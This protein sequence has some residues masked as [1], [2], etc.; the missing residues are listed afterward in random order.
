M[1]V[2]VHVPC[3]LRM[4]A[5]PA[6]GAVDAVVAGFAAAVGRA[7]ATADREVLAPRSATAV[8]APGEPTF[9][10]HGAMASRVPVDARVQLEGRLRAAVHE[11]LAVPLPRTESVAAR[12]L[13]EPAAE[14]FDRMRAR[15]VLRTYRVP[16]YN[17]GGADADIEF[18]EA[19]V[20]TPVTH[21]WRLLQATGT[22]TGR[23]LVAEAVRQFGE[24]PGGVT[25][26]LLA[27]EQLATGPH[28]VVTL[29]TTPAT[30]FSFESFG[31]DNYNPATGRFDVTL[32]DPPVA[33]GSVEKRSVTDR[34]QLVAVIDELMGPGIEAQIQQAAPKLET[35][36]AAE[37]GEQVRTAVA[38]EVDRRA[39]EQLKLL[40][41]KAPACVVIVRVGT[42]FVVLIGDDAIA[43][44]LHWTGS[45]NVWPV[46]TEHAVART[47]TG[48]EPADG[49]GGEA[50]GGAGGTGKGGTDKGGGGPGGTGDG[51]P[52][53]GGGTGGGTGTGTGGP[54]GFVVDPTLPATPGDEEVTNRFPLVAGGGETPVCASFNGEPNLTELGP[55]GDELRRLID[56]IAFRLQI[57]PCYFAAN[58]CL[59]AAGA[60]RARAAAIST[61]I[62]TSERE[63]FTQPVPER[64][65]DLGPIRFRPVASPATQFLRHL[66][67]VVP[68]LHGLALFALATYRDPEH[69]PKVKGGW[70]N[71]PASWALHFLTE[72]TPGLKAAV[73]EIFVSGSQALLLQ[74]LLS[75]RTGI[76]TR[77][78][79]FEQYAPIFERLMVTQLTDYA[80][81]TEL[82]SA[83][84][85]H[86]A[87]AFVHT[88]TGSDLAAVVSVTNPATAWFGAA[89]ALSGAFLASEQA[90]SAGAKGEIVT[91]DGVT[92]IR[93]SHGVLWTQHEL[94]SAMV[95]RRGEA[96]GIDPL[97]KQIADVPEV[98]ERFQQN[99]DAIRTELRAV[100]TEMSANNTEMLAKTRADAWFAFRAS[101]ISEHIPSATVS[102]S[103][104]A[105]QGIHL[106]VHEELG[107][108]F[109]GDAFYALGID[110][111][112]NGELGR[113]ELT[114]FGIT[115][116]I[117][118]LSVLCPPLGIA[119]GVAY[120]GV[121]VVRAHE[122]A[123]IHGA[124]VD[125]ELVIDRATVELELFA[126][127]LG[128]ALSLVP[129][130]GAL[131]KS[132]GRGGL[133]ALRTGLRSG[134]RT[135]L[136]MGTAAARRDLVRRWNRMLIE[137]AKQD[138][139]TAFVTELVSDAVL[140]RVVSE[141]MGPLLS[142]VERE[143]RITG[144]VGGREGARFVIAVLDS[145]STTRTRSLP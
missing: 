104:Y 48:A 136:R 44:T 138:L 52:G 10:W 108:F 18:L 22:V 61:Y 102:G 131:A 125:P 139:L 68:R 91:T 66:A 96:E 122:R 37:Y 127:Y 98:L 60:L 83:L 75:S 40:A 141:A 47:D 71:T 34:A 107:E 143:A 63:G 111:L 3:R 128:L 14:P 92:R 23:E 101:Q 17:G 21:R 38:A 114:T 80:E 84:R 117:T 1:T 112:F 103:S 30:T 20:V 15:Q 26:G 2:T 145:G 7:V 78:A 5:G 94:E 79:K 6:S 39:D 65:G 85:R 90:T 106:R 24:F 87:A 89:R 110:G 33:P 67:G 28:W 11:V 74:L 46:S 132:A 86:E 54:G 124:L 123:R 45:A 120:A 35:T 76:E 116:G 113:R 70:I 69:W 25:R 73:G 144:A 56:D 81:L 95:I 19:E 12:P 133:V 32:G 100:L 72:F 77:L 118:L 8:L 134:L 43:N 121:E 115:V 29:N 42:H 13:S 57:Q 4:A 53:S 62:T 142:Y 16:S 59:T 97:V 88:A 82:R 99:R 93:D 58:F 50:G 49:P 9:R 41:G 51:S 135:G 126:A 27:K 105:L 31:A 129:V 55:A 109:A 64:T 119:A 36:S 137:A 130:G 140:D